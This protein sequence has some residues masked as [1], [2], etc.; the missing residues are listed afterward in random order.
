MNQI[1]NAVIAVVSQEI[2]NYYS[3]TTLDMK[4]EEHGAPG[5]PPAGN[6]CIKSSEWLKRANKDETIDA[7]ALL[8][9]VLENYMEVDLPNQWNIEE[10]NKGRLRIT[11][12]LAKHG[13]AYQ[14]GGNIS[15][16]KIA[17]PTRT[18]EVILRKKDLVSVQQ[19]FDRALGSVETDPPASVTAACAILEALCKIYIQD[20]KLDLPKEQT[21]KP[22]WAVVQK[23][24]GFDPASVEDDDMKRILS[25]LTSIVDG[26][27]AFRT[28]TGSAHG[29]GRTPYK[30]QPRHARLTIHSAHTL[31]NFILE[32]WD[33]RKTNSRD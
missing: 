27:G 30:L 3:R 28:H 22:L 24:L 12:T 4:F 26:L 1:P 21:I 19:E 20:E 10:L 9:G 18:L 23:H 11:E 17:A 32:T 6:K 8:G 33:T 25:G 13:L 15:G 14:T 16:A 7:L 31:T 2:Q 5:E 29:R